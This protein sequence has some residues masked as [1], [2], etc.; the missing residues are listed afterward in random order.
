MLYD[1][2]QLQKEEAAAMGSLPVTKAAAKKL[3]PCLS[4]SWY[5]QKEKGKRGRDTGASPPE[6]ATK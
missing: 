1:L 4:S 6:H 5:R 3:Q 2:P